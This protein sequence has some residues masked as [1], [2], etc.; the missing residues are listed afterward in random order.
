MDTTTQKKGTR[1]RAALAI[2]PEEVSAEYI[3]RA[4]G[5]RLAAVLKGRARRIMAEISI[6][7]REDRVRRMNTREAPAQGGMGGHGGFVKYSSILTAGALLYF[8][9]FFSHSRYP[10]FFGP[11]AS[12]LFPAADRYMDFFNL[13]FLTRTLNPYVLGRGTASSPFFY[14]L[15]NI[16]NR[17]VR[18]LSGAQYDIRFSPAGRMA[19]AAYILVTLALYFAAFRALFRRF[20]VARVYRW[21]F[22]TAFVL[23]YPVVFSIDRGNYALLAGGIVAVFLA[24]F[25]G[26]K[27]FSAAMLL[28]VAIALKYYYAPFVIVF[29]CKRRYREATVCA[30]G[31]IVML[32]VSLSLC[33]GGFVR[34]YGTLVENVAHYNS[35]GNGGIPESLGYNTSIYALFDTAESVIHDYW[36]RGTDVLTVLRGRVRYLAYLVLAVAMLVNV[37]P[38]V[39][40]HDRFLLLCVGIILFP[41]QSNDYIIPVIVFPSLYW[42]LSEP[43]DRVMPWLAGLY[44]ICKRYVPLY[45]QSERASV[46]VQSILNPLLLLGVVLYVLWIRR[47]EFY[48][49]IEETR[50]EVLGRRK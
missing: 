1:V 50:G 36:N 31:V 24:R 40:P 17:V 7:R 33:Q 25:I 46:T 16:L 28:A 23:S 6:R 10:E 15:C 18:G 41:V 32:S 4:L 11:K 20:A 45:Y 47:G 8:L 13:V 30:A 22:Y 5:M 3:M 27:T 43:L 14:L 48:G 29:I 34:N 21:W 26:G 19:F 49:S 2:R 39:R 42:I 12:L 9:M 38:R 44:I 35:R 37:A